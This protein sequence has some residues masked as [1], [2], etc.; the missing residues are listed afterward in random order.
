MTTDVQLLEHDLQIALGR[1]LELRGRRRRL[2][3]V[4]AS[5]VLVAAL[6]SAAAIASGGTGD[7]QLDPTKWA[8]FGGGSGD[9]GRGANAHANRL[10]DGPPSTFPLE[11]DR[12]R[13]P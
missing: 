11:H 12:G 10:P 2:G 9:N 7:L 5:C 8:I 13:T 4:A 1:R 6:L 3:L